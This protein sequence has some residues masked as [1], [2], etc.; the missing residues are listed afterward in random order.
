M[1]D[2]RRGV[3]D[4][5]RAPRRAVARRWRAARTGGTEAMEPTSTD[6]S[7]AFSRADKLVIAACAISMLIVQM[8]WFALNLALPA[9][10][11][12]FKVPTTDLQWVVSG[13]MLSIGALMVTA[14]RLADIYGRRKVIVIGLAVFG[15]VSAVCGSAPNEIWLIVARVVQGIGA[16]LIFPVSI[17]VVSGTFTG[18]RQARAIGI[19]LG[20]AAIGS[21]LGPFV[22]GTFS[23][24][25]DWRGVFF[26]NIPFCIAAIVLMLRYVRETRDASADR[27]IDLPGMFAITGGLVCISLAFDRGEAWGWTSIETLGTLIGGA[28]LLVAFVAI[29]SR[30]R[31]PLIDLALFRNRAFD[32]V[33]LAGSLSNVVFCFVAV[34]SA[35][36]L[37]QARGMSPFSAGLVFLALS[38][39]AGSA[40]YYSGRLAERFPADRLMAIGMLISAAGIMGLTN[41]QS[42]WLY[43]PLFLV[44]GVGLGLAWALA[45][46]A[47]Q[48]VV[49][50][51]FIGAASGITLTSLVMLGAVGVA[52]AAAVLELLAGSP[53]AAGADATAI[54]AVLRTGAA[55]A[56]VGAVC[57]LAFGRHR[58]PD[59]VPVMP[60]A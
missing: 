43:T 53:A 39:G 6:D 36:Y 10:G 27:H 22:G 28:L 14:G 50:P 40:S 21:A 26:I 54:N 12:H 56:F 8:D 58:T 25:L 5:S 29:E 18:A 45:S 57:L 33:V 52:I 15:I 44:T 3:D 11:R 20:F 31:S 9:I 23:E 38:A 55:L 4:E 16:A 13:Y 49:P 17:A 19:V 46:V 37:Q 1:D 30:T 7:L 41:V 60:S 48:A 32:A 2:G 47:T 51:S 24:Y 35:L 42:L 34:F 59:A